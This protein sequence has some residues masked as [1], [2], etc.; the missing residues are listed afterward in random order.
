MILNNGDSQS[1]L[2]SKRN[3]YF[4]FLG[5]SAIFALL[6]FHLN[7]LTLF[8]S[9][10]YTYHFVYQGYLPTAHPKRINGLFSIVKSQI[11][12]WQLW[13]GRF[14]AHS[15]VQFFLQFKK[16]Y[17]DVFNTL[18]YLT[19]MF[20]L[21]SISKVKE[22]VKITPVSYLLLF[23]F[24]WFYLPEIGK[25]VL[26]VSGSGNYLW[27]S[28]IY[29]TYFKCII[30]I[31]NREISNLKGIGIMILG[32]LAGA[33]NENSSP[34][35][36]LMAFLY[37]IIHYPYKSKG[38]IFGL[39]SLFTGGLGFLLMIKSP[40]SQ[41]R[42]GMALNFD[43]LKNNFRLILDS[44]IQNYWLI[45]ILIIILLIILVIK[46]VQLSK[47]QL[48]IETVSL[49]SILVIGHFAST[50][51]LV[52]SPETPKRTFFGAVLFIGI[53]LFSLINILNQRIRKSVF[54]ISLLLMILFV[55]SYL[56]V[57]NDLTKSFKEVSN[58]YSILYDAPQNSDVMLPLLSTPKTD[59]NAYQLTSNVKTDPND[60][61]NRWMAVYF[62][63]K[64]IT[65]Y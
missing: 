32:F 39:G 41:K 11:N 3:R 33:C 13:N 24:L 38:T 47:V 64:T 40:G 63:K 52:L 57:N 53:V 26:W 61:F 29:L 46:K 45:Y 58:Q 56:S 8:T 6:I 18:A 30:S 49:L 60:W 10:D 37:L 55:Q 27:T 65:G 12:H 51:A 22:V 43:V 23:I 4:W 35:L 62:E 54:V 50:F 25:S 31:A 16:V 48:S 21:L 9:D 42:G 44:L 7:R 14:V 17:F 20:L 28:V 5:L 19:L 1:K 15:I 59:Y 36:L 2:N 34:A